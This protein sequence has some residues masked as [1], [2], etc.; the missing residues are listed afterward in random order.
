MKNLYT[1]TM[2]KKAILLCLFFI[3]VQLMNAQDDKIKFGAYA[4]ALQKVNTMN[5]ADTTNANH[6]SKGNVL[7]DLGININPDKKTEI[8]AIVRF[9][10]DFSGFYTAGASATLR[11]LSVKGTVAKIFNYQVGDLYMKL[12]PYTFFNNSS[13]GSVNEALIFSDMRRDY[14]NY[15]NLS[16]RGNSWWQQ[17]AATNF[18]LAFDQAPI[19]TIRV[20]G[21]FLRNRASYATFPSA[22]HA[23]GKI[24]IT[25][26]SRLKIAANYVNLFDVAANVKSD[27][28]LLYNP[29]ATGEINYKIVNG[30]NTQLSL[31]G[32]GGY[33]ENAHTA[34]KSGNSKGYFYDAG[35]QL[36]LKNQHLILTTNYSYV[37][38]EFY[39][40]AAQS[41]RVNYGGTVT[42]FQ[43]YNN[44]LTRGIT[45]FDLV[46]DANIYNKVISRSLMAY[47]PM[48][49]NAQPY[50][51]AT[52]NRTGFQLNAQ[53]KDSLQKIVADV[54][55]AYLS[56]I[57][58]VGSSQLRSFML[59]KGAVDFNIHKF[60]N[61]NKRLILTAGYSFESTN[62]GG[63][64][65]E[66]VSLVNNLA[67]LGLE[68]EVFK[69]MSV[70]GGYKM[71]TSKGNEFI[72]VRNTYNDLIVNFTTTNMDVAQTVIAFGV[73]Y[74]FSEKSYL[75]V[76]DHLFSYQDKATSAN[77]YSLSQ[78][79]VM[80]NMNF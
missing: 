63:D 49:G 18:A 79:L 30:A 24:T 43:K 39:S 52:P 33:S 27:T 72:S 70:L 41:K 2:N 19:D 6:T 61:W 56:E 44:T 3:S 60:L 76:Q 36:Q 68:V 80:F 46:R 77:N 58:G 5:N 50:G 16:N 28:V 26:S 47:N 17:G 35:L 48:Y 4:R 38:P 45:I 10:N 22:F 25:Q 71:L 1:S 8:Q 75:T 59:V 78:I 57:A 14:T 20:D 9:N 15:E 69:K 74:R 31:I 34:F 13:E 65:L 54:D 42:D 64:V 32:E 51:K 11:Q 53:Y 37:A 7:M 73:K 12:T 21:F 62:R 66:K 55:A 29:V 40:S 67:D 23:G